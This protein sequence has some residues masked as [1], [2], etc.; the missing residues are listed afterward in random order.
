MDHTLSPLGRVGQKDLDPVWFIVAWVDHTPSPLGWLG[1]KDQ[2]PQTDL[3]PL[4]FIVPTVA[5]VDHTPP[6]R[7]RGRGIIFGRPA[8]REEIDTPSHPPALRAGRD[9]AAVEPR[10]RAQKDP[11]GGCK[12]T[13]GSG[14]GWFRPWL[15][16]WGGEGAARGGGG[17]KHDRMGRVGQMCFSEARPS[18]ERSSTQPIEGVAAAGWRAGGW[19][20]LPQA[21]EAIGLGMGGLG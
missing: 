3:D 14:Q 4:W 2:G 8:A 1:Q 16:W 12:G 17:R 5:W 9:D 18:R 15:R 6:P 21:A 19:D 10:G 11:P 7:Q 20:R 13:R